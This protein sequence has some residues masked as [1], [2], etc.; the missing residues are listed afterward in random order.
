MSEANS[1]RRRLVIAEAEELLEYTAKTLTVLTYTFLLA[2][3]D[4]DP[5]NYPI[6]SRNIMT[7]EIALRADKAI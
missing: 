1:N 5:H 4:L 7:S 3:K 2:Y 6:A